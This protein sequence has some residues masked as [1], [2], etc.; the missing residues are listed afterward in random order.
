MVGSSI[1]AVPWAFQEAGLLLGIIICFI[2]FVVGFYT[3]HLVMK[4]AK[5]DEDFADTVYKYF[6]PKGWILCMMFSI[7]L[8]FAAI[9]I[10]Y[11][12]MR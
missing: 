5:A 2:T 8:I 3:C 11:E 1:L 4:T 9:V 10:Y 7:L 12:Y 6:G